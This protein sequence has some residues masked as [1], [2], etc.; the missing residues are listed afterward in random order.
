MLSVP[1]PP[2]PP[3]TSCKY[4]NNSNHSRKKN[5]KVITPYVQLHP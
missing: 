2:S 5:W 3:H 4:P 1:F